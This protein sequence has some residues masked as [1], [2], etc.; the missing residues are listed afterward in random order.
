MPE[1][2]QHSKLYAVMVGDYDDSWV[3]SLWLTE[4]EAE[5]KASALRAGD[6]ATVPHGYS[7]AELDAPVGLFEQLEAAQQAA[8]QK[9]GYAATKRAE[10]AEEQL[11]AVQRERDHFR[12]HALL[13]TI[14][15]WDSI[16]ASTPKEGA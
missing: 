1:Q 7:V 14:E 3:D 2:N 5:S 10:R 9:R 11:E 13:P 16:P 4:P 8:R 6:T 15:A 12:E